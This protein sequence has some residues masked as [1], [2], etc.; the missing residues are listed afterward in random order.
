AGGRSGA[1]PGAG[2]TSTTS[3]GG[4][5][6]APGMFQVYT[7]TGVT[8]MITP[9]TTSPAFESLRTVPTR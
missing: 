1:L 5:G 2:A 4:G 9:M 6:G 3:S 7:P 8:P